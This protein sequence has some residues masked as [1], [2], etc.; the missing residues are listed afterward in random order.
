M[1]VKW[2]GY[3]FEVERI[4]IYVKSR[5]YSLVLQ[6]CGGGYASRNGGAVPGADFRTAHEYA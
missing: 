6:C 4:R 2:R 3:T 5:R 1:C